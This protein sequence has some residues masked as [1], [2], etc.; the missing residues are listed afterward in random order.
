MVSLSENMEFYSQNVNGNNIRYG[1][2]KDHSKEPLLFLHGL[3][4]HPKYYNKAIGLL[5]H[6]FCPIMPVAYG[7]N[8]L[9]HQPNSIM[10]YADL[11]DSFC[12]AA[13]IE[14]RNVVGHSIGG[15]VAAVMGKNCDISDMVLLNP[16]LANR[17]NFFKFSVL[18]GLMTYNEIIGKS[19]PGSFAF[20]FKIIPQFIKDFMKGGFD[21]LRLIQDIGRFEYSQF[22]VDKPLQLVYGMNDEYFELDNFAKADLHHA[23]SGLRIKFLVGMHHNWPIFYGDIVSSEIKEANHGKAFKPTDTLAVA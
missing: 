19:G 11:T 10:G 6:D 17:N 13:K 7:I 2:G 22:A 20:G 9:A 23:F 4:T 15:A 21:S 3:G 14:P 18:A 8:Y 5:E 12:K 16:V 1:I